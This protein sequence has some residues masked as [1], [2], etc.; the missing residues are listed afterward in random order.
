[1]PDRLRDGEGLMITPRQ[2]G[3]MLVG[4]GLTERKPRRPPLP[5]WVL[6]PGATHP[7]MGHFEHDETPPTPAPA[8]AIEAVDP[9]AAQALAEEA[10][11]LATEAAH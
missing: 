2:L 1:M 5:K 4:K 11:R 7:A 6:D 10:R 9:D 3:R 8:I